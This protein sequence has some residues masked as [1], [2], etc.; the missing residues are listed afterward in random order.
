MTVKLQREALRFVAIRAAVDDVPVLVAEYAITAWDARP[1]TS[2]WLVVVTK[3]PDV[4]WYQQPSDHAEDYRVW[5]RW[6][7]SGEEPVEVTG[8]LSIQ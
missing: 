8:V 7:G 1:V 3:G 2:D 5:A 4:G 6:P